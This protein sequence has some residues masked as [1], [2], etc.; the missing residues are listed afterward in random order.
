MLYSCRL[1][2]RYANDEPG[3]SNRLGS[4]NSSDGD[5]GESSAEESLGHVP[6]QD[7]PSVTARAVGLWIGIAD[8]ARIAATSLESVCEAKFETRCVSL[9]AGRGVRRFLDPIPIPPYK[10]QAYAEQGLAA[11]SFPLASNLAGGV[12]SHPMGRIRLPVM[13]P[14]SPTRCVRWWRR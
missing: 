6:R 11:D 1:S 2:L 4:L 7:R 3:W 10:R 5:A 8:G 14:L 9:E 13:L 12:L